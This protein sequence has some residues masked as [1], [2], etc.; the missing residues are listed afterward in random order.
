MTLKSDSRTSNDTFQDEFFTLISIY[1]KRI[2]SS[3]RADDV[4]LNDIL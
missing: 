4:S 2:R 1:C 3:K